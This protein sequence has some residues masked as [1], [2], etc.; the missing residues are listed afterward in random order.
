MSEYSYYEF[1]AID[2]PLTAEERRMLRSS[3]S[4][5]T[6]SAT[7]FTN[8]YNWGDFKGNPVR[9]MERYFDAFFYMGNWMT[10]EV[11]FRLPK[12]SLDLKFAQRY[13]RSD[14]TSARVHGEHLILDF[15]CEEAE[16]HDYGDDG[17]G[18]L[19][20]LIPLRSDLIAGDHRALY[21]AWLLGVQVGDVAKNAK[22]P[23][24]PAGLGELTEPLEAFIDILGIDR[25]L[26]AAAAAAS[27][28]S[29]P[30]PSAKDLEGW[31]ARLPEEEKTRWLL[32]LVREPSSSLRAELLRELEKLARAGKP[33]KTQ[34][35]RTV[36]EIQGLA[37]TLGEKRREAE[38]RAAAA[39]ALR[40]ERAAAEARE[41]HLAKVAKQGSRAWR[42]VDDLIATK[43][44][45]RYDDAVALL[46]DLRDVGIQ[47]GREDKVNARIRALAEQHSRKSTFVAR[48]KKAGLVE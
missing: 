31:I 43:Q 28:R 9:W 46:L 36:A 48:L 18:W 3:S 32:R 21:L 11:S 33:T 34:A 22:E 19:S 13:C 39:E 27:P 40:R 17:S 47:K 6:I 4:R 14:L 26:V 5:A 7:R 1:Q 16:W 45:A 20:S 10:R 30:E 15:L 24:L 2:R 35:P 37:A 8:Y 23:P 44:P 25:D 12:S 42:R 38:A 29:R 41:V